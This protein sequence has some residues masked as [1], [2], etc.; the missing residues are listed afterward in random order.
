MNHPR[1][2]TPSLAAIPGR[3][4]ESDVLLVSFQIIV[5]PMT[6]R[7]GN[8]P[9]PMPFPG[10]FVVLVSHFSSPHP[11]HALWWPC[12]HF[13]RIVIMNICGGVQ[14]VGDELREAFQ[15]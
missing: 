8:L 3:T 9:S 10:P 15:V 4:I 7:D 1:S 12:S 2:N 11:N 14:F 13:V 6:G 5:I